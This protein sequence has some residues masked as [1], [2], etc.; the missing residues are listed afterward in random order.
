MSQED[1]VLLAKITAIAKVN[2]EIIKRIEFEANN[3]LILSRKY[4]FVFN[5]GTFSVLEDIQEIKAS[6]VISQWKPK[7]KEALRNDKEMN[8]FNDNLDYSCNSFED[9]K[10]LN[11]KMQIVTEKFGWLDPFRSPPVLRAFLSNYELLQVYLGQIEEQLLDCE[12]KL[13]LFSQQ[14]QQLN[15]LYSQ[16][17]NQIEKENQKEAKKGIAIENVL[18]KLDQMTFVGITA[19]ISAN[20]SKFIKMA[21]GHCAVSCNQA[22]SNGSYVWKVL[23]EGNASW[24]DGWFLIGVKNY[25]K[26]I[27]INSHEE[28]DVY[29][30]N[31]TRSGNNCYR[32]EGGTYTNKNLKMPINEIIQVKLNCDIK[33]LHISSNNWEERIA[34]PINGLWYPHFNSYGASFELL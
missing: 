16:I 34:L 25:P 23:Y 31:V 3:M 32:Y 14:V 33:E 27:G 1:T 15:N 30:V 19:F 5:E 26:A 29:G 20:G 13:Y 10:R 21:I 12:S 24:A 2:Q 6:K 9:I 17:A 28:R 8:L 18:L 11:N 4:R 7:G 22:F